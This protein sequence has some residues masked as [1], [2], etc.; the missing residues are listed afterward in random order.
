MFHNQMFLSLG[1]KQ[2]PVKPGNL[3]EN[4]KPGR[5]PG[6]CDWPSLTPW[7]VSHFGFR[8]GPRAVAATEKP[9]PDNSHIR[10]QDPPRHS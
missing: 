2:G 3:P 9:W 4:W 5:F 6:W 10:P 7:Q 8:D 1:V